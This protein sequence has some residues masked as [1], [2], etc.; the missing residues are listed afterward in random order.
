MVDYEDKIDNLDRVVTEMRIDHQH[1][2]RSIDEIKNSTHKTAEVLTELAVQKKEVL[3]AQ[4]TSERAHSR[5]DTMQKYVVTVFIA[6]VVFVA[7][8]LILS[9]K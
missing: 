6:L 1:M 7:E 9:L 2:I 4:K 3:Q 5:I 8:R